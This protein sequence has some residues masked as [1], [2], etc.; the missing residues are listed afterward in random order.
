M[1][2]AREPGGQGSSK[3]KTGHPRLYNAGQ[4]VL[5]PAIFAQPNRGNVSVSL[6]IRK[7]GKYVKRKDLGG[8]IFFFV[9]AEGPIPSLFVRQPLLCIGSRFAAESSEPIVH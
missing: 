2:P 7:F 4:I 5:L 9:F 8:G 1:F 6:V 3:K